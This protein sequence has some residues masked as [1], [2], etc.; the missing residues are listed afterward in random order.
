MC[1][2]TGGLCNDLLVR[3]GVVFFRAIDGGVG[4][5][6]TGGNELLL[7]MKKKKKHVSFLC[8]RF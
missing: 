6:L 2:V 7:K 1:G 8:I 3:V 5:K 4:E